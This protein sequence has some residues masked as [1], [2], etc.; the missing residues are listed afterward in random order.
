MDP[1]AEKML[2]DAAKNLKT[3]DGATVVQVIQH[4]E[5][6]RPKEFKSAGF[7]MLYTNTG[8]PKSIGVCYWIGSKRLDD[9]Q[10]CD[11]SF[12]ING[13]SVTPEILNVSPE[14]QSEL[15][16]VQLMKGRDVFLDNIDKMY[17]LTCVEY[18]KKKSC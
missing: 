5:K 2:I 13:L 15:T 8:Q 18:D 4:V 7:E 12:S 9:D 10:F 14:E 16:I 6:L 3:K 1:T 11:I 17:A